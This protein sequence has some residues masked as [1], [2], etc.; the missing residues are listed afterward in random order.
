MLINVTF[1][2]QTIYIFISDGG[3]SVIVGDR[4]VGSP[5]LLG[6]REHGLQENS[7]IIKVSDTIFHAF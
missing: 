6:E 4:G 5:K 7:S 2:E 1:T 3:A